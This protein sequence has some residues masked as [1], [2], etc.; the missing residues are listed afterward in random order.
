MKIPRDRLVTNQVAFERG[1]GRGEIETAGEPIREL[2]LP[3]F[4]LPS[5]SGVDWPLPRPIKR[6]IRNAL[7]SKPVI[8]EAMCQRCERCVEICPAGALT[9]GEK[10]PL[11]DY[12]KCIRCYCCQEVCPEGA[13]D[14]REGW[15]SRLIRPG[16]GQ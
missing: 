3:S 13:V 5:L 10:T 7:S 15:G 6:A 1:L 16:K 9:K 8:R 12:E 2:K 11:F 4:K 14:L